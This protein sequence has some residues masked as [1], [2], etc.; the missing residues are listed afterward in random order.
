MLPIDRNCYDA[1]FDAYGDAV[2][3][4]LTEMYP[5]SS[6]LIKDALGALDTRVIEFLI[7]TPIPGYSMIPDALIPKEGSALVS[8][9][10][11]VRN[12]IDI[13]LATVGVTVD[14]ANHALVVTDLDLAARL[15]AVLNSD[16]PFACE[17]ERTRMVMAML[18]ARST[19][20][21]H[22][23]KY[24]EDRDPGTPFSRII[25]GR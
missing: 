10:D 8:S 4:Q 12:L 14:D 15:H 11:A 9:V 23:P 3:K 1:R 6:A 7:N 16:Q 25:L 24:R 13:E 5:E 21:S 17:T 18:D 22:V 20:D 19:L 2:S